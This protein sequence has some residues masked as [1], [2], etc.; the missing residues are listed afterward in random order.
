[1]LLAP[2]GWP[3]GFGEARPPERWGYPSS[4]PRIQRVAAVAVAALSLGSAAACRCGTEF[5]AT[6]DVVDRSGAPVAGATIM[7]LNEEGAPTGADAETDGQGRF[8]I[9]Y[10]SR[11]AT[12]GE[13]AEVLIEAEGCGMLRLRFDVGDVETDAIVEVERIVMPC[14]Q[15]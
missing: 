11:E 4:V 9:S 7:V 3:N 5:H 10:R 12:C 6:G 14:E 1:M 8:V 13:N 15:S 2:P